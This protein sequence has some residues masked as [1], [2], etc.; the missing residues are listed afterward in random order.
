MRAATAIALLLAAAPLSAQNVRNDSTASVIAYWEP[1]DVRSYTVERLRSGGRQ[2]RSTYTLVLKVLDATDSTYVVECR[3]QQLQVE[4][5]MPEDDRQR[6]VFHRLLHV[7]EGLR[8]VFST[9]ETGIPLALVNETEVEEHA[10]SALQAILDLAADAN[11]QRQMGSSLSEVVNL[12]VLAQDA[13]EDIGNLLFPFGVAYITGRK[14]QVEAEVLNP[15]GGIPF[16]TRQQFTMTA[17]DTEA[18]TARMRMEQSIDPKAVD[19]DI[20]E[21][22]ESC[23]G[24]M[25]T[26]D[27][28]EQFRRTIEEV[29][30][31]ETMDIDVDLQGAWTT[32]LEF[33]RET[34]VR[35]VRSTDKRTYVLR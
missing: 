4:A 26:G 7:Q 33:V 29:R 23:G 35:G 30:V 16:R 10:R 2:G 34:T 20:E 5:P 27:A 14:E 19:D 13:L 25:L 21:L 24:G 15:L 17:F 6:L 31:K 9:D 32:R 12:D 11:E 28:R 18:A 3:V 8:V 1:G 22:I